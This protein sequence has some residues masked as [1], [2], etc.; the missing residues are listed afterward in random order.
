MYL[1]YSGYH[2][3]HGTVEDEVLVPGC[4]HKYWHQYVNHTDPGEPEDRLGSVFGSSIGELFDGFYKD[5]LWRA[6]DKVISVLNSRI[7]AVVDKVILKETTAT[8]VTP[9]GKL[10]WRGEND[11]NLNPR[12]MYANREELIADLMDTLPLG[13]RSIQ[14]HR[15]MGP[16]I[17]TE[18]KLN[19][20]LPSGDTL[21]GRA[22][23]IVKRVPPQSDLL[24]VDGKGSKYRN[25]YVDSTQLYWYSMLFNLWSKKENK[26][27]S[28]PDK[29]AFL[30]WRLPAEESFEEV[31][32]TQDCVDELRTSVDET[33][34]LIKS[35][36]KRLPNK[37]DLEQVAGV[38]EPNPN[39]QNCQ[40]CR[41]LKMCP[42]G[43]KFM[44]PLS[45]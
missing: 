5:K 28:L 27:P 26:G 24:I 4:P 8:D 23:L 40:F 6:P 42:S 43:Q 33:L 3:F 21:G 39:K 18:L 16:R 25:K 13:V 2:C 44:S 1:S 11:P 12:G 22:D 36:E 15:L 31:T 32:I 41:Y 17:D 10:R 19:F 34:N 37:P 30:Y 14:H 29:A 38:F 35:L 9:A 7:G 20:K 45:L